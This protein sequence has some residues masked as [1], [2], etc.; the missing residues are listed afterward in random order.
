[1]CCFYP[2]SNMYFLC[3]LIR[4]KLSPTVNHASH[5]CFSLIFWEISSSAIP[6]EKMWKN[7]P[8][9]VNLYLNICT[10]MLTIFTQL[11]GRNVVWLI[12]IILINTAHILTSCKRTHINTSKDSASIHL[13]SFFYASAQY[14]NFMSFKLSHTFRCLYLFVCS[15]LY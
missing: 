11:R 10:K 8:G 12:Q 4:S 5:F 9:K 3:I 14:L 1:M 2:C 7:I 13:F 15:Y 6:A